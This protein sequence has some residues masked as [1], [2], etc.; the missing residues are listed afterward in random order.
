[1]IYRT[2]RELQLSALGLGT[3][4]LPVIDGDASR[5]DEP[6]VREMV[7][8]AM[9]NGIN[10]YDTAYGYHGGQSEIVTGRVLRDYPRESYCLATKFPSYNPDNVKAEKGKTIFEEQLAKCGVDYF[11]FYL[12]HNVNAS[13]IEPYLSEEGE[14]LL[15]YLAEQK[16]NGKIRHLGFSVHGDY[17]VA[18]RF[19]EKY[20]PYIEFGQIQLN[21]IDYEHQEARRKVELFTEYHIPIWVMEPL[22]GGRLSTLAPKYTE[23]LFSMRPDES[24]PGWAFR[25]LQ[26]IPHVGVILS[27]MSDMQQLRDNLAIF[28]TEQPLTRPEWEGLMGLAEEMKSDMTVPCTA[29]RYCTEFCPQGLDIPAL[30]A[31][32][33]DNALTG[34]KIAIPAWTLGSI[35]EEKQPSACL[36]CRS[37]EKVCPQGIPI[38]EVMHRFAEAVVED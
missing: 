38:S 28:A 18:R 29:C 6:A 23:R 16:K 7:A 33:N 15:A 19:L 35:P 22:R 37:C 5:I 3:M 34:K 17:D 4:R 10:Y 32:F 27:G 2:F 14:K 25:F 20:G 21:W 36:A 11:D 12:C 24:V 26:T 30:I 8:C 31:Q 1:M 9:E 13:N